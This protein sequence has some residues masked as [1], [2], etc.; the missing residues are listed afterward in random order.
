MS[1]VENVT[2][3]KPKVGGAIYR[4]PVGSTLPT[5]AKTALDE[6]FKGMGYIS[7]DGLTNSNSPDTDTVKAWGGDTVYVV[8]NGK[9]DTFQGTFIEA[10]NTEV[11]K[12]VYGDAN[13]TGDVATGITVKANATEAEAYAYVID[14]ILR[15]NTLKRIVIPS[16]KVTEIGDITYSDGDVVGYE[17]TLNAS[18]DAS[19][20]THYEY[21][22]KK[23]A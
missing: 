19:G 12:M 20:N 4:A 5:D 6:A 9:D 18:P 21:I 11:L 14:M 3:G 13:V 23:E 17:T 8:Q 1:R 7:E 10:L 15:D 16:A 2:T 22:V